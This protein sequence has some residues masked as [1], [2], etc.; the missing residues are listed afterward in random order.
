MVRLAGGS[1]AERISEVIVT[2]LALGSGVK[3]WR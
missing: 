2:L 1:V 3:E